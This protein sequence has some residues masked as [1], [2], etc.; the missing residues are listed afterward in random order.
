MLQNLK[1]NDNP[2]GWGPSGASVYFK[3]IPYAPYNKGEKLG[4]ISDWIGGSY[5]RAS[6][7]RFKPTVSTEVAFNSALFFSHEN[8]DDFQLVDMS[9]P[10]RKYI[11]NRRYQQIRHQQM[12]RRR[13][14]DD[15]Q[16]AQPQKRV[17]KLKVLQR[18]R[19]IINRRRLN[20]LENKRVRDASV[21]VGE[22]WRQ[23]QEF[24]FLDLQKEKFNVSACEDLMFCG[25]LR[26]YDKSYDRVSTRF[27][28]K[29]DIHDYTFFNVTTSDD[30][31]IQT[32]AEDENNHIFSTDCLLSVIMCVARSVFPWDI[33]VTKK[34]S[35]LFFDKRENSEL[36]Y[37]TVNETAAEP[38]NDEK[39]EKTINCAES[40][41][42]EATSINKYFSQQVLT[43]QLPSLQFEHSN[44]FVNNEER[45]ASI[46]YRY[47]RFQLGNFNL[48]VRAELD[49]YQHVKGDNS[50]NQYLTIKALN[51]FDPKKEI[52]W[53]Q[54]LD[55]Q[56]GAVLATE[57]KNNANKLSRWT[58]Q[59]LLAG[60][61]TIKLGFVSRTNPKSH[62]QHVILGTQSYKPQ[63]FATQINLNMNT[64]WGILNNI[65]SVCMD[66]EDGRYI[67]L[68]DP[69][70]SLLRLY[71]VPDS[72][73]E[74]C[75]EENVINDEEAN[76]NSNKI[77]PSGIGLDP[78]LPSVSVPIVA[79]LVV[80][81][82]EK[83]KH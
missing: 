43:S 49:G 81:K 60:S 82:E 30:P 24:N 64:C 70:K 7:Q 25:T 37:I 33:I 23:V 40:L 22:D 73:F 63:E 48:V 53:R 57:L 47:R 83:S 54:K 39:Y 79:K 41:S 18:Q 27:E 62:F 56:R 32:F 11:G 17:M 14:N 71:S 29:L 58:I 74:N 26:M 46:A 19:Y 78:I 34:G 42:R 80:E 5:S 75:E 6:V 10:Q 36:D 77:L 20:Q 72:V 51:E 55:T 45:I 35:Q 2:D 8:D 65:V 16:Q 67:L 28:R 59:S 31:I 68:K 21:N 13:R 15:R 3:N 66:Q 61:S 44:P 1:V 50:R 38:P 52:D 9:K 12:Q 69:N 76:Q 4:K